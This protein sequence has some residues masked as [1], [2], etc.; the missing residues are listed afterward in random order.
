MCNKD[1]GKGVLAHICSVLG[2]LLKVL[3]EIGKK[4]IFAMGHGTL[5]SASNMVYLHTYIQLTYV[6]TIGV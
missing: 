3:L 6:I 4:L 1:V 5:T 2:V